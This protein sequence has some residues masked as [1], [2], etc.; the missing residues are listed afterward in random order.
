[1]IYLIA[2]IVGILLGAFLLS[3]LINMA[4]KQVLK[5]LWK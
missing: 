3:I 5:G 4:A 1:M 2:V